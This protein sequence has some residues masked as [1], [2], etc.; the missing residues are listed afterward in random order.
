MSD[1]PPVVTG[2]QTLAALLGD[3]DAGHVRDPARWDLPP[4]PPDAGDVIVWGAPPA[5]PG[6]SGAELATRVARREVAL[7]RLRVSARWPV[8]SRHRLPPAAL[9][10]GRLHNRLRRLLLGGVLVELRGE[11]AAPRPIDRVLDDAGLVADTLRVTVSAGG[12]VMARGVRGDTAVVLRIGTAGTPAD[13]SHS[14]D[15]LRHLEYTAHAF[16]APR[17]HAAGRTDSYSWTVESALSGARPRRVSPL[18]AHEVAEACATMPAGEQPVTATFDDLSTLARLLPRHAA[19]LNELAR[20]V[21]VAV[22]GVP[23]RMRHGD[24][25]R[26]N[27]LTRGARISGI[28]DWDAWHPA[29]LPGTDLLQ[30]HATEERM[31]TRRS[32]GRMWATRPW[33]SSD[34]R[35]LTAPYWTRVGVRLDDDYGD[36]LGLAWWATEM[37]G[38]MLRSGRPT[39]DEQWVRENIEVVLERCQ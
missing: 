19:E 39:R 33:D 34:F 2:A 18:L 15:A 28:I 4:G 31:A 7:A 36:L 3:S 23:G 38:T 35:A 11:Q 30:L 29:A 37:A 27:L 12:G 6:S 32:L 10:G 21:I 17:L 26:G 9:R 5:S 20:K 8:S 25:W 14:A 24:L 13:P 1:G 22:E 16:P